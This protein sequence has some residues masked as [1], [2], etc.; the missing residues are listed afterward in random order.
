MTFCQPRS[1]FM[2]QSAHRMMVV[3]GV[4]APATIVTSPR[5]M[6]QVSEHRASNTQPTEFTLD[7]K[8]NF[9]LFVSLMPGR[10]HLGCGAHLT[11]DDIGDHH[12][13]VRHALVGIAGDEIRV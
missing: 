4:D 6:D 12:G 8:G 9:R 10:M 3:T 7:T 13:P 5:L 1:Y 11:V 2:G